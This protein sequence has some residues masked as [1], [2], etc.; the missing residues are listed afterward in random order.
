M[1]IHSA[2]AALAAVAGFWLGLQRLE[3]LFLLTA[4]FLVLTMEMLN[5]AL[6]RVVDLFTRE[7]HPLAKLAK[8]AAAGGALLA[9]LYA[10]AV[11]VLVL[12]P[13]IV[14]RINFF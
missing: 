1:K 8:N 11:A 10:L 14:E 7:Y 5:T 3:W 6:E 12:V 4:I 2:A 13:R 9:S